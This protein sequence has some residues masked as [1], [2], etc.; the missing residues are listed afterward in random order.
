MGRET[1]RWRQSKNGGKNTC[2][3]CVCDRAHADVR[4][5]AAQMTCHTPL[6]RSER[7]FNTHIVWL[8]R[9]QLGNKT[10][11]SLD[12]PTNASLFFFLFFLNKEEEALE[13]IIHFFSTT[14]FLPSFL[15]LIFF[16]LFFLRQ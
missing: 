8:A 10:I 2:S 6:L 16:L 14:F 7:T 9:E 3:L 1:E 12:D 15:S 4:L 5:T 11:S 13:K